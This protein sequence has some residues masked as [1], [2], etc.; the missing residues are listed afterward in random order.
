MPNTTLTFDELAEFGP[1]L[2]QGLER[3]ANALKVA[4]ARA[5]FMAIVEASPVGPAIRDKHPGL[6]RASTFASVGA[7]SPKRLPKQSSYPIPGAS[8]FDA[9]VSGVSFEEP[10]Y[11]TNSAGGD[12]AYSWVIER[13]RVWAPLIGR[14]ASRRSKDND[15]R[16]RRNGIRPRY[17]IFKQS[18]KQMGRW[19]GSLQ[20]P[21]GV[22]GPAILAVWGQRASV[23]AAALADIERLI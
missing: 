9:A 2:E 3:L 15:E 22:F 17:N 11:E 7:P 10:I 21:D 20:A 18:T 14:E 1:R 5:I 13:G 19:Y 6:F 12:A 16:R 8:D 4:V 23:L